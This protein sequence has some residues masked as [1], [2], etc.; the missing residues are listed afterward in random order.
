MGHTGLAGLGLWFELIH[1]FF[2]LIFSPCL[3]ALH[4][5]GGFQGPASAYSS[6]TTPDLHGLGVVPIGVFEMCY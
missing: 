5:K 1:L 2:L 3:N 4:D 6:T